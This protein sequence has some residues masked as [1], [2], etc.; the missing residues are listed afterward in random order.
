MLVIIK[1]NLNYERLCSCTLYL[2]A[3]KLM[4]SAKIISHI[5]LLLGYLVSYFKKTKVILMPIAKCFDQSWQYT[6]NNKFSSNSVEA[7]TI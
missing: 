2:S 4:Q 5:V 3:K 6:Y 7:E 1:F